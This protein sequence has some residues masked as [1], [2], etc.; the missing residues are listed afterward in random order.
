[1]KKKEHEN[2]CCGC[3]ICVVACPQNAI[4]LKETKEGF[5]YPQIDMK[6]CI[7]CGVCED[8]CPIEGVTNKSVISSMVVQSLDSS[9]LKSSASGGFFT[10]LAYYV[11][12]H[13]G[14][15]AGV[16]YNDDFETT[17]HITNNI[18]EVKLFSSSKYSQANVLGIVDELITILDRGLLVLFS[19]TPCQV[20]GIKKLFGKKYN[21]LLTVD[22][23]CR[24]IPSPL[25]W[26]K[27]IEY[28]E[29]KYNSKVREVNHRDKILGYHNGV[30]KL[31]FENKKIYIGSV[32][33]DYFSNAFHKDFCSRESCYYCLYKGFDRCSDLTI[34]DCW[35][36]NALNKY[37]KD[38]DKGYTVVF[39]RSEKAIDL[40]NDLTI[41]NKY[42][43]CPYEAEKYTGGM[44]LES[45]PRPKERDVFFKD[46]N[47]LRVEDTFEKYVPVSFVDKIKFQ[48]KKVL[49]FFHLLY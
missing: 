17:Y 30:M 46:L 21:N 32:K 34:F 33:T 15:V 3:S 20:A 40:I 22:L 39:V 8:I 28:Q 35:N 1:M 5:L 49:A 18:D 13:G 19:G 44:L 16:I 12:S 27:Y 38:N 24:G 23:A 7:N 26:R 9:I 14:Y 36:P 42:D 4:F 10:T 37:I 47:S 45:A 11:V 48:I 2:I 31:V 41:I 25:V 29:H 6:L 43:I